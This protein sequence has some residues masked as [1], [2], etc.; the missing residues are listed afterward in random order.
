MRKQVWEI[1][2]NNII[3]LKNVQ[4]IFESKVREPNYLTFEILEDGVVTFTSENNVLQWSFDNGATWI[5]GNEI[6]VKKGDNVKCKGE[7]VMD[8]DSHGYPTGVGRFSTTCYYNLSG[9]IASLDKNFVDLK[10]DL[11]DKLYIACCGAQTLGT[12]SSGENSFNT[13]YPNF[14]KKEIV[15]QCMSALDETL[16]SAFRLIQTYSKEFLLKTAYDLALRHN[17]D[18]TPLPPNYT[19][20]TP[21][22]FFKQF[23]KMMVPN[24]TD[25]DGIGVGIYTAS[26]YLGEVTFNYWGLFQDNT[27]LIDASK[28]IICGIEC[29]DM[30]NGCSNLKYPPTLPAIIS[31]HCGSMFEGCTSLVVA[32]ELPAIILASQHYSRMFYNCTSLT[33]APALP[34]TTLANWCYESMFSGCISLTT[35]PELPAT[36]LV[37]SCYDYMFE[38]CSSLNYIKMLAT[39]ISAEYCLQHWIDGVSPT[40]TFVKNSA[41]T[42][43]ESTVIPEG[44]TVETVDV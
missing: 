38:N 7:C 10:E 41:A 44:W 39:D 14:S 15:V 28:L 23:T 18:S 4:N 29:T 36:K 1:G 27:K 2:N 37:D 21:E 34:A 22:E 31:S 8:Y 43:D 9:N 12:M 16:I 26:Q 19:E 35:A 25:L 3:G 5:K 42:W 40:G 20:L 33:T 11:I 24:A 32:P 17:T 30:F 13:T 6:E